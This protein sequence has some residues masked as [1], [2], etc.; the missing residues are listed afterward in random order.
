M[1]KHLDV[2]NFAAIF[3]FVAVTV[4]KSYFIMVRPY[5]RRSIQIIAVALPSPLPPVINRY[6]DSELACRLIVELFCFASVSFVCAEPNLQIINCY[7]PL[8]SD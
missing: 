3:C 6:L 4:S 2:W 7:V 8:S 5:F 1:S